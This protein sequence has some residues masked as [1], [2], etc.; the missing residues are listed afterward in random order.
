MGSLLES[1]FVVMHGLKRRREESIRAAYKAWVGTK[2]R[3][4]HGGE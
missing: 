1:R 4:E 2:E 3:S